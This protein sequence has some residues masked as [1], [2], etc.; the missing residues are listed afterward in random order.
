LKNFKKMKINCPDPP[1]SG[2]TALTRANLGKS[3]VSSQERRIFG[4]LDLLIESG[5]KLVVVGKNGAGKTTLLRILAG[6]DSSY[7]GEVRYGANISPAYF[8]QDAVDALFADRASLSVLEYIESESPLDLV[9]HARD[10]LGAFLFRG[11]DVYKSVSVLSG[12]EK[13][14][15]ALLKM[16]LKPANLLILDE[17]TNHLDLQSKDALMDALKSFAGTVLFV[18]H[19]RAFMDGLST[20]TLEISPAGVK[21]FYGNYAY[22]LE[23]IEKIEK[24]EKGEKIENTLEKAVGEDKRKR[25]EDKRKQSAQ[26]KL[27]RQEA[28]ILARIEELE[29]EKKR[30]EEELAH[31]AVY[32]DYE[33]SRDTQ[34]RI[35]E[36]WSQIE[37]KTVEWE[38]IASADCSLQG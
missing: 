15:L 20:K 9:S 17:P 21:L 29:G 25:E 2:R 1:R 37:E 28:E 23:K 14:R 32:S 7:E 31:P 5:E 8:S 6:G 36:V 33:K 11:D 27:Q 35:A 16:L 22:Y 34:A 38:Q 12:G 4:G 13:S 18:S 30:L 10:M 19:D 3:Y 26:R 24:L